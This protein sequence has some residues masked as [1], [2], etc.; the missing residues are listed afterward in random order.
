MQLHNSLVGTKGGSKSGTRDDRWCSLMELSHS[1]SLVIG[2]TFS[3]FAFSFSLGRMTWL[4]GHRSSQCRHIHESGNQIVGGLS[5][6]V[7]MSRKE[8][9]KDPHGK[10]G[11]LVK[12]FITI[13]AS[14][15]ESHWTRVRS[16]A[17]GST[18]TWSEQQNIITITSSPFAYSIC[19]K[20]SHWHDL[21]TPCF[22]TSVSDEI[23]PGLAS[24][25]GGDQ[26]GERSLK[27]YAEVED[28]ETREFI[29]GCP[30]ISRK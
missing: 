28:A 3:L 11:E 15:C 25:F 29:N 10:Y 1:A 30:L 8:R 16:A 18:F 14:S 4:R 5:G 13:M 12:I 19:D 26:P 23:Y 20:D 9:P 17:K 6:R 2:V 27:H 22:L 24:H 21:L 7:A